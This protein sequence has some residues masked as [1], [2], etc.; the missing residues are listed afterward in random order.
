MKFPKKEKTIFGEEKEN[1]RKEVILMLNVVVLMGRLTSDPEIRH[2][3]NDVAVTSF[4]IAVE[5]SYKS[6]DE[7]QTDFIDIVAW[8]STAEFICKYFRKGQMIAIHGS[9]QTGTYKDK[10]GNTRKIFE[11][12]ADTAHFADSKKKDDEQKE[13]KKEKTIPKKVSNDTEPMEESSHGR[14]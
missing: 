5:R 13:T 1:N 4:S 3:P 9:I 7:R 14:W 6:G 11:V 12:L 10:E 2:T 8:R